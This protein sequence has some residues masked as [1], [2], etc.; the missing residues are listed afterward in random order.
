MTT[1]AIILQIPGALP[2]SKVG[3]FD[4]G[5]QSAWEAPNALM[6]K[7]SNFDR[8]IGTLR[9]LIDE[10]RRASVGPQQAVSD[11]VE[12]LQRWAAL[13]DQGLLTDEEFQHQKSKLL[14]L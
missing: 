14:G 1:K 4:K 11:P 13:R 6:T 9:R 8:V 5:P 12:Q 7:V 3:R 2:V 10:N